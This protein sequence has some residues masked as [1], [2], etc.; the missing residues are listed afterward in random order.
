MSPLE[1]AAEFLRYTARPLE[2]RAYECVFEGMPPAGFVAALTAFRRRDGGFGGAL[3]PDSRAPDSQPLFVDFAL[4]SLHQ[5]GARA[6]GLGAGACAFLRAV[7]EPD[8]SLP[9]LLPSALRHPRADHWESLAPPSLGVTFGIA[10]L[11]HWLQ[12]EDAWLDAATDSCWAALAAPPDGVHELIG[13]LDF[14]RY[15]PARPERDARLALVLERLPRARMLSLEARF[16]G[17]AL[18][19]LHLAPSPDAAARACFDDATI[20]AHLDALSEEQQPDGGWPLRWEPP[21]EEAGRAWR[22]KWTLDALVVLR[23]YGRL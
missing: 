9:Y 11:L 12:V 19:P 23:A 16:E 2:L 20:E 7:S 15:A 8:G 10:G 6:S 13:V 18:T 5:V 21:G 1:A 22:G 17:Y 14:L 4:K 3:E